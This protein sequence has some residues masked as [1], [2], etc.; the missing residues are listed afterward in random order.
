VKYMILLHSDPTTRQ[1]W[2]G[3]TD[4]QRRD[5]THAHIR[6]GQHLIDTGQLVT[7]QALADIDQ[8]RRVTVHHDEVIVTDGP[9]AEAKDYLAGFYVIEAATIDEAAALAATLPDARN[10]HVEIRPVIDIA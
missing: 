1:V 2:D 7:S 5:F 3:L 10:T 6:F 8:A 9:F 4:D